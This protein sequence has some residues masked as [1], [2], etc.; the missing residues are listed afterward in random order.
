MSIESEQSALTAEEQA[1]LDADAAATAGE[2]DQQGGGTRPPKQ[3]KPPQRT[4]APAPEAGQDDQGQEGEGDDESQGQE[5][6]PAKMVPHSALHAEREER[7]KAQARAE[8]LE[9]RT[10]IILERLM[11]QQSAPQ[12]QQQKPPEV[13]IPD[14]DEDP[15]G[16]VAATMQQ[17]AKKLETY[18]QRDQQQAQAQTQAQQRQ[19]VINTIINQAVPLEKE[20]SAVTPD[21]NDASE[22]L[23]ASRAAEYEALG[24][25][26][27]QIQNQINQDKLTIAAAALDG[28]KNP[29]E[30]VYNL[31]KLR[32]Y[33]KK[34][35]PAKQ[36]Q[37]SL[38][39]TER[40]A[41][42]RAGTEQGQSLSQGRGAPPRKITADVLANMS[43]A[44]FSKAIEDPA[45]LALL[46][47]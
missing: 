14:K 39:A 35:S 36:Q 33:V 10:N 20:F 5:G 3:P 17:M 28:G 43:D 12:Q 22:F 31:A 9:K 16:W 34:G 40:L 30:V 44:E 27:Q 32:G 47:A 4:V 21:Y 24:W 42:L 13:V 29:A 6:K 38:S 19:E 1:L 45:N 7:K 23:Q 15:A 2:A 18:E 41:A 26:Q 8:L 11:A 25:T 37:Q 46:G